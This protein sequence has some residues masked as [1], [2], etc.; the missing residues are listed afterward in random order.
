MCGCL[1]MWSVCICRCTHLC[2]QAHIYT[3]GRKWHWLVFSTTALFPR[4]SH[5]TWSLARLDGLWV[6]WIFLHPA[7]LG[8]ITDMYDQPQ[9]LPGCLGFEGHVLGLEQQ[10]LSPLLAFFSSVASRHRFLINAS[11]S[12][13]WDWELSNWANDP[14][15]FEFVLWAFQELQTLLTRHLLLWAV[16]D[17][18]REK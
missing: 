10:M 12:Q 17:E 11:C 7:M 1:C 18:D 8:G 9:L 5:W 16:R 2:A 13:F 6:P 14:R 15:S 3:D 4:L